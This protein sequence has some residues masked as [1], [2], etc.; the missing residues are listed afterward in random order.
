M[1]HQV[2]CAF[3]VLDVLIDGKLGI[4]RETQLLKM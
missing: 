2:N 3:I 1:H 4:K